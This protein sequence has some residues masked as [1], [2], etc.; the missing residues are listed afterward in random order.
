MWIMQQGYHK[1]IPFRMQKL[2]W[3]PSH[4]FW[5]F[6]VKEQLQW[7]ALMEHVLDQTLEM[8]LQLY[9]SII[10]FLIDCFFI[11]SKP[12]CFIF[13][14]NIFKF[15]MTEKYVQLM[16]DLQY[17]K[18]E[19]QNWK[20][21]HTILEGTHPLTQNN[22]ILHI[23]KIN[24]SKK[25][26]TDYKKQTPDSQKSTDNW[27]HRNSP[28]SQI[29]VNRWMPSNNKSQKNSNKSRHWNVNQNQLRIL[30]AYNHQ[31]LTGNQTVEILTCRVIPE[32]ISF[33]RK[34]D[35]RAHCISWEA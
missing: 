26:S 15:A 10:T 8:I 20:Q 7:W 16:E 35:P 4:V 19:A 3:A 31:S 9:K 2:W 30:I 21:K 14:E 32:I 18:R 17:S 1:Y 28:F 29:A 11:I 34:E 6:L 25:Q 12:I 23:S 13:P 5:L 27:M 33:T 24:N 22:S